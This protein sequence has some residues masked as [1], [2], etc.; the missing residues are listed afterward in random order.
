VAGAM[1]HHSVCL[2]RSSNRTCGFPASGFPTDFIARHTAA[3]SVR[4]VDAPSSPKT[5]WSENRRVAA[6][7]SCV[8]C[9][10]KREHGHIGRATAHRRWE[11]GLCL[12]AWRLNG[13]RWPARRSPGASPDVPAATHFIRRR[14][15]NE[16][17]DAV[18]LVTFAKA[19]TVIRLAASATAQRRPR[20]ET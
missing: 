1:R 7:A 10:E 12:I 2:P 20:A 6:L 3:P 16:T 18:G 5:T 15:T 4:A 9:G 13:R 17:Y 11:Y 19:A 14:A 8:A